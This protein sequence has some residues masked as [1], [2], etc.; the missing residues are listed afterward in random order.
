[1]LNYRSDLYFSSWIILWFILSLIINITPPLYSLFAAAIIQLLNFNF[2]CINDK[3]FTNLHKIIN[4]CV[5]TF[6][7]L[8]VV[9]IY[10]YYKYNFYKEFNIFAILITLYIIYKY[11]IYSI[12]YKAELSGK[13]TDKPGYYNCTNTPLYNLINQYN[14]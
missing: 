13:V 2:V 12:D 3:N 10:Y 7:F 9:T 1:M 4:I 6:K 11:I 5:I 8:G 14:K